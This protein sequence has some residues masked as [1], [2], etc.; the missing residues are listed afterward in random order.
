LPSLSDCERIEPADSGNNGLLGGGYQ[1]G[2]AAAG[3]VAAAKRSGRPTHPVTTFAEP[4][5]HSNLV[6]KGHRHSR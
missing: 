3:K 6:N 2:V 5:H 1:A 4:P